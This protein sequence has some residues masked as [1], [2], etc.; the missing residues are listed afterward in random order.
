MRPLQQSGMIHMT[1]ILQNQIVKTEKADKATGEK[2][3]HCFV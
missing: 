2:Q 1:I 3:K